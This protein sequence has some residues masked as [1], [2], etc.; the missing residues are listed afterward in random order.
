MKNY[1]K[2]I[3]A[4]FSILFFLSCSD[5]D[6]LENV[7]I[8]MP[9]D[10]AAK[11][12][13]KQDNSGEVSVVPSATG[14][15]MFSVDFGDGSEISETFAP[16]NQVEH[17]Y[18]EGQ[19]DVTI[20]AM[21]LNGEV[22]EAT[23]SL[24]V[25]F[26]APEN[27]EVTI[28]PAQTNPYEISVSATADNASG[29]QV[30]FGESEEETPVLLMEGETA[31]Y[32]Y[33]DIGT[34]TVRVVALSGGAATTEYTEEVMIDGASGAITFPVTF[35]DA[36]V[37]YQF[38]TFNGASFEVVSNPQLS[39][40]HNVE[41]NVGAITNS[42]NGY[43]GGSFN[44]GEAL[45]FS[46]DNKLIKLKLYSE[47]SVPILIKLE[48][49]VDGE[50]QNE[51][52]VTHGGT[53]WE[54]LTFD[55]NTA[56]KSY[57]DGSQGVGEAF[58]PT[59]QYG[60]VTMFIDG[61][62]ETSGTFYIDDLMQTNGVQTAEPEF[63]LTFDS[64]LVDYSWSGF[65]GANAAV[66]ENPDASGIN[67]STNVTELVKNDGAE[68]WAGA[69]QLLDGAIDFS[70]STIISMKTWSPKTGAPI[71]LKLENSTS[72]PDANGNPSVIVEVQQTT[73]VANEWEEL[74]FDLTSF[75][76]FDANAGYDTVVVFYDYGNTEGGTFYFDD[77]QIKND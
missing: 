57:I 77:V 47:V 27:L 61:P 52:S 49:G 74:N 38:V 24:N 45:D 20:Y 16:G 32:E 44:L 75:A 62:G 1:T 29:Y 31:S 34:Y 53:G 35:D 63:P 71:L 18:A 4:C 55:F 70:Q 3:I 6:S 10:I 21:N 42:G 12:T 64:A 11:F 30:Y 33:N 68:T 7:E 54:E 36:T 73:T 5:D 19:Y 60:T 43:E 17:T 50:R 37:D 28:T 41:T 48:G 23:Q 22:A 25:S 65:G 40:I 56:T 2:S 8:A 59:G 15:N 69:S 67:T 39:G 66:I 76:A 26:L 58:V 46:G 13:V 72:A 51:V 14:A 9:S